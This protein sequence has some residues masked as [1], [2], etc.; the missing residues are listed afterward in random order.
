M[1]SKHFAMGSGQF[2]GARWLVF[3]LVLL[4]A[5]FQVAHAKDY[6]GLERERMQLAFPELDSVS[7]PQGEFQVRTLSKGDEVLGYAFQSID[8]VNIPAYSGKPINMQVILDPK[9]VIR[10]AYMLEHHEPIVLIGIPEK[11]IHDFNATYTDIKVDQ[12]VIIGRSS[13]KNAVTVDAVTGATVTVMVINEAVM[14]SAHAVAVSLGL[15][16]AKDAAAQKP[17]IVRQ[18]VYQ[19]ATWTELTGNGAIRRMLLTRGDID[20]A[21]KGSEA[22]G[23]DTAAPNQVKDTFIDLYCHRSEPADHRPQPAGRHRATAA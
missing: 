22:E 9:G 20:E 13:D 4:F 15:V 2:S 3:L 11:K 10:D 6:G 18:D 23:V 14:R 17:A 19:P 1:I 21:F 5:S 16:Q 7:E 12:R 8:V